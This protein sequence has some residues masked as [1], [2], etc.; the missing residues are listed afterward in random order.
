MYFVMKYAAIVSIRLYGAMT[1]ERK[2]MFRIR[3][4]ISNNTTVAGL[5]GNESILYFAE[6]ELE[7]IKLSSRAI[8]LEFYIIFT[9]YCN[10]YVLKCL[11]IS[12][13]YIFDNASICVKFG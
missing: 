12:R 4:T 2:L 3:S 1:L 8:G 13:M 10:R 11:S 5:C 7:T 6:K 9:L